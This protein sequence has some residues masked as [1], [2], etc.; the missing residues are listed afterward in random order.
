MIVNRVWKWHFGTGIVNT[1]SNF[2]K[3]GEAPTNP[4]LLEYLSQSFID[5]GYSI[6]ALHRQIML[7]AVYQLG[8]RPTPRR[9]WPRTPAIV[10]TG[11][12]TAGA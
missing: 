9:T 7:S 8:P 5:S 2:G 12:P 6:K 10:S 11:V 3:L 1:P 4:E